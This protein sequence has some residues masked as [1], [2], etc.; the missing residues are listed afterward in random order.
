MKF[1]VFPIDECCGGILAHTTQI[2]GRTFKKGHALDAQDIADLKSNG[3]SELTVALLGADDVHENEA[4]SRV[5]ALLAGR[6]VDVGP[7]FTGRVN[8]YARQTGLCVLDET[9]VTLVNQCDEAITV[10]TVA[11]FAHVQAGQM[12]ATIKIIPFAAPR[13]ALVRL[14]KALSGRTSI[15]ETAPFG[16]KRVALI[17]TRLPA[18]KEQVLAKGREV[19][20][21]RIAALGSELAYDEVSDHTI[22]GV[23]AQLQKTVKNANELVLILGASAIVDRRDVI[24]SAIEKADGQIDHFG[25]PVDPGNLL[26]LGRIGKTK[27]VGLPGCVRSPKLNG[28]DWV[29]ERFM[30]D[31]PTKTDDITAMGIGGLLK[32]IP[33]RP[34]P[35]DEPPMQSIKPKRLGVIV[36]A[37]GQSRR[38]GPENKLLLPFKGKSMVE[39]V[40]TTALEADVGPVI[41]VTGHEAERVK[42][43][44]ASYDIT[45]VRN[46]R[47][48]DGLSTSIKAGIKELSD[49]SVA[50]AFICLG[51]MPHISPGL[52]KQLAGEFDPIERPIC[53]PTTRGK[54]GNPVLWSSTLFPRLDTIEGDSG[55][56][57][58]IGQLPEFVHEVAVEDDAIF[59][60]HDTPDSLRSSS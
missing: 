56:K 26:L 16:T 2:P 11:P 20:T 19:V 30:A 23:T 51:D 54:M 29:I 34:Q 36:L 18:T 43:R 48:A 60:D 12:I 58:L 14:E 41:V 32:E 42:D 10:A 38:M 17:S 24:P 44:L 59:V 21:R 47:Y 15:I 39:H 5:A 40:V 6:E 45:F 50:G 13:S 1:D 27:V 55:A 31:I 57:S 52:I 4:A 28:A 33:T 35:R 49:Q 3:I 53:V 46:H 37:A 25:M 8:L 22:A 9:S 7:A